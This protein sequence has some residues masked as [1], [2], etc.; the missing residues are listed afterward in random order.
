MSRFDSRLFHVEAALG[1]S[2]PDCPSCRG[3][4]GSVIVAFDPD[5]PDV[6]PALPYPRDCPNCGRRVIEMMVE[7]A[8]LVDRAEI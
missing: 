8:R 3:L 2:P 1:T 4:P 6:E 5:R 7:I